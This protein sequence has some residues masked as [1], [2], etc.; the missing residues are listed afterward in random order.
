MLQ[1]IIRY[2]PM[3]DDIGFLKYKQAYIHILPWKVAFY[4]HVF[5]IAFA[6]FAGFTQFSNYILKN[7]RSLHRIMGRV[8][9]YDILFINFP[10][11]MIMAIYAN[12]LL[13][14]KIAFV[15]LDC[16]WT[17]FTYK[18]ITEIRAGN[19]TAHKKYMIRSYA[20]TLSA[21]TLRLWKLIIGGLITVDPL[22]LYMI[23]AWLGFIPNL[24]V[25][26]WIIRDISRKSLPF[27]PKIIGN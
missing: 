22:H 14:T 8:Y 20:L 19:I 9:I 21:V 25:A 3:Q 23:D 12:G 18:A 7:H 1:G 13:P 4:T 11:T 24:F 15:I 5:T 10:A 16:L 17:W 27:K 2:Y 6:L 26:E